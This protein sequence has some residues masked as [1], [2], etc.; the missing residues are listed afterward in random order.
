MPSQFIVYLGIPIDTMEDIP[1]QYRPTLPEPDTDDESWLQEQI[2][3]ATMDLSIETGV[4]LTRQNL[5]GETVEWPVNLRIVHDQECDYAVQALKE[6][7]P[8]P[9]TVFGVSL[10]ARYAP[11]FLDCD[12]P[13]GNGSIM[14][15]DLAEIARHL[16]VV[17]AVP[18]M[19][20]STLIVVDEFF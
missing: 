20:E 19:G 8:I 17:R 2:S 10:N 3:E 5:A 4:T 13:H 18:G 14:P 11:A 16:E 7:G 12:C 9:N 15:L 6:D 1:A